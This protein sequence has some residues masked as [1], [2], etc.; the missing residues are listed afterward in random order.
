[1]NRRAKDGTL[2]KVPCP[3]VLYDYN[4]N[5]NFVD[6]FDRHVQDYALNRKSTKWHMR[7][8]FHLFGASITNAFIN[9]NS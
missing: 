9:Y 1:M 4:K 6:N 2:N 7:M 8:V 5:M 3:K